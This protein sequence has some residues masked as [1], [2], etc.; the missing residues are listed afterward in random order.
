[1]KITL[2]IRST[3]PGNLRMMIY[4]LAAATLTASGFAN[5]LCDELPRKD[6]SGTW[7]RCS[8]YLTLST[9]QPYASAAPAA[10]QTPA[11]AS[12]ELEDIPF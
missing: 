4:W 1:M 12:D 7:K 3:K 8:V 5:G 11:V 6:G 10:Q 2:Y 9:L